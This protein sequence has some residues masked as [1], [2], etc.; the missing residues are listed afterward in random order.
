MN[1]SPDIRGCILQK[2][3]T[4][5][6]LGMLARTNKAF[7]AQIYATDRLWTDLGQKLCGEEHWPQGNSHRHLNARQLAMIRTCPWTSEPRRFEVPMLHAIRTM[8]GTVSVRQL[9]VAHNYC[10]LTSTVRGGGLVRDA[11]HAEIMTD[12]YGVTCR[13]DMLQFPPGPRLHTTPTP[14]EIDLMRVLNATKWRPY[15]LYPSSPMIDAVRMVHDSLFMVFCNEL[16]QRY[17]VVYF[18]SSRTLS[19]LHTHRCFMRPHWKTRNVCV[20]PGEMWLFDDNH[21]NPTL[22]YFGPVDNHHS[23]PHTHPERGVRDAFWAAYRGNVPLA[24]ELLGRNGIPPYEIYRLQEDRHRLVDAVMLSHSATALDQLLTHLPEFA[25]EFLLYKTID[26]GQL[27]LTD[28]II[29][30]GVDPD[31]DYSEALFRAIRSQKATLAMYTLLVTHGARVYPCCM[32]HHIR[33][34]THPDIFHRLLRLW[35]GGACAH[36]DQPLFVH[37][38]LKGGDF[39]DQMRAAAEAHPALAN[40]ANENGLTPLMLAAGSLRVENIKALI[41]LKADLRA[42]DKE[43]RSALDWCDAA[44]D[45]DLVPEWY[46]NAF[47]A[48]DAP[49]AFA[50]DTDHRVANAKAIR[51]LLG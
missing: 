37:W 39:S 11:N 48:D 24:L 30:H 7:K 42:R 43:N 38:L 31:D 17:T 32:M 16:N 4:F 51:A 26:M 50:V 33:P 9:E 3:D 15:E 35:D 8:G 19:V 46:M 22:T 36:E 28:V 2:V 23:G 1:S 21:R 10:I 40:Q 5:Q 47:D 20:R 41:D 25:T 45:T 18:V 13:N 27:A 12:A 6:H 29:R 49:A 34:W 44:A 14:Q